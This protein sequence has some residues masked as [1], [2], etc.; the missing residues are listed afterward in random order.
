MEEWSTQRG[1]L[2]GLFSLF[3]FLIMLFEDS[4]ENPLYFIFNYCALCVI[5]KKMFS[6]Q[7]YKN[8]NLSF[9]RLKSLALILDHWSILIWLYRVWDECPVYLLIFFLL[10]IYELFVSCQSNICG[11]YY[12]T[13]FPHRIILAPGGKSITINLCV[14]FLGLH[15]YYWCMCLFS[16]QCHTYLVTIIL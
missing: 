12:F 10:F 16:C 5:Y 1:T 15:L 4:W 6:S 8:L 2:P 3:I 14:G 9:L 7:G 11:R 13:V